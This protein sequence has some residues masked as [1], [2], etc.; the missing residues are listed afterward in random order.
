MSCTSIF[1]QEFTGYVKKLD[2]IL[3]PI[4]QAK[5]EITEGAK[6]FASLKTYFDGSFKFKPNKNQQ[7][8]IKITYTAYFDTTY[9]I[10]TDKNAEPSPATVTAVLKKDGMRLLGVIRSADENFPIKNATI[11]LRNVMTR[12]E[13]RI[14]TGIDGSYNFKLEYETNYKVS[15]DKRSPGIINQYFDT[16][17]YISTVGFDQPLDYKLDVSLPPIAEN[18]TDVREGYNSAR[19]P[20]NKN[21]KP[22][23]DVV[24]KTYKPVVTKQDEPEPVTKSP[25]LSELQR[26]KAVEDSLQ[27][28]KTEATKKK[29][30]DATASK[31]EKTKK[32]VDNPDVVIIRDE[33][34][35]KQPDTAQYSRAKAVEEAASDSVAKAKAV[36]EK[37]LVLKKAAED[38]I[39]R[40]KAETEK[41]LAIKKAQQDSADKAIAIKKRASEDSLARVVMA[42]H[43]KSTEDSL[44]RVKVEIER[45]RA[46]KK[47]RQ[48]S[49]DKAS[50]M[51]KKKVSED[52]LK[53]VVSAARKKATED[54]LARVKAEIETGLAL[55]KAQQDSTVKAIAMLKKKA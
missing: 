41:A 11:V 23:V 31:K 6:P 38:S 39:A 10:S 33:P 7:Y 27:K 36:F 9:T 28:A 44:V 54:S 34:V 20:D 47:T 25:D 43:K 26:R 15:I 46:I 16:T 37:N 53:R 55:K 40:S 17:F 35:K 14:T 51:L 50:A 30:G 5:V 12:Q 8:T 42:A 48:D 2:S 24:T 1:A 45:S 22:A 32:Q 49:L 18:V 13:D 29:S 19:K 21:I 52:S 3:V 4:F